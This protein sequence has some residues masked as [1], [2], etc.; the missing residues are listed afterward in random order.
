MSNWLGNGENTVVQR[1]LPVENLKCCPLCGVLNA[2]HNAEC[3]V[4]RWHGSFDHDPVRIEDCL[5]EL[6]E[7]CPELADAMSEPVPVKMTFWQ[8]ARN[9]FSGLFRRRVDLRV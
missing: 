1:R 6:L 8:K 3:F 7:R 9:W 5:M 4:C 2:V